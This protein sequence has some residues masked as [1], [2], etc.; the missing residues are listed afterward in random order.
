LQSN[1]Y[2]NN[3]T[4]GVDPT[5]KAITDYLNFQYQT[6]QSALERQLGQHDIEGDYQ[7][8]LHDLNEGALR[9]DYDLQLQRIASQQAQ[10]ADLPRADIAANRSYLD[11]L[12]KFLPQTRALNAQTRDNAYGRSQLDYDA[13]RRNSLSDA[14]G[15]GAVNSQGLRDSYD[16]LS[17]QLGLSRGSA[18]IQYGRSSLDTDRDQAA[19]TRD[20][21]LLDNRNKMLDQVAKD[22]GIDRLTAERALQTGLQKLG[23]DFEGTM[24]KISESTGETRRQLDQLAPM[25]WQQALALAGQG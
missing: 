6:Q 24:R 25:L 19:L 17:R 21:A 23:L 4:G 5:V 12:A 16:E 20:N 2:Y 13:Q 9:G 14:V 1:P 11:A 18:D 7:T 3:P 15:R 22:Y 8:R 10:N